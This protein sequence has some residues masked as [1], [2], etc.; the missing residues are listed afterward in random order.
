MRL[1]YRSILLWIFI[2]LQLSAQPKIRYSFA[3]LQGISNYK[4]DT[5]SFN[6]NN[7]YFLSLSSSIFLQAHESFAIGIGTQYKQANA[8]QKGRFA[9]HYFVFPLQVQFAYPLN[10]SGTQL[11]FAAS[12]ENGLLLFPPK[13][14]ESTTPYFFKK[15]Y[16]G[17]AL[18]PGIALSEKIPLN[19]YL[20]YNLQ[21]NDASLNTFIGKWH[22][23]GV[24]V[25]YLLN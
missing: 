14:P 12:I 18:M 13:Q 22:H 24:Q 8:Y 19:L 1:F 20:Y 23:Y 4:T 25:S 16:A 10:V 9:L 15:Y 3:I 17:F 5:P 11:L 2:Y 6:L 21:M 7:R